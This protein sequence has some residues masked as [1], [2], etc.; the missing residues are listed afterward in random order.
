MSELSEF[1]LNSKA[2]VVRLQ[3]LEI[4]HPAFSQTYY[5]VR[6]ATNGITVDHEDA[7]SHEY[8]YMPMSITRSGP[9]DDLDDW[10]NITLGDLGE[11]VP[12][13]LAAVRAAPDGLKT[14][15]VVKYREYRSD[16]LSAPITGPLLME[17]KNFNF[18]V[19]GAT[20]E[21]RNPQINYSKT[22]ERMTPARFPMLKGLL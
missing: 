9:T 2:S 6:N 3:L 21:A 7:S 17:V 15:P 16:D 1:F 8:I 19:E 14:L 4:S 12:T 11:V 20:F 13:E 18:T 5:L 10:L 22:G